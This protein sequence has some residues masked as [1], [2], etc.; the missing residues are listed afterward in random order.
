MNRLNTL[1]STRE[2]ARQALLLLGAPAPAALVVSVHRALFDGD[3]DMA[4]L[5]GLLRDEQRTAAPVVCTGLSADLRP[6]HVALAEWPLTQRLVTPATA[7]AD[8]LRS[9]LRVAD[10]VALQTG[11][12]RSADLLL[13][14]LVADVPGGAE[15]NDIR[16]AVRAELAARTGDSGVPADVLERAE[17]LDPRQQLFGL[18]AMPHQ[19]DG[20]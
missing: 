1:P 15:A 4:S 18:P 16:D 3:L 13:R 2:Q 9:V 12:G 11:A 14:E 5:A 20:S 7:R 17:A 19:R 8:S 6:L 10:W